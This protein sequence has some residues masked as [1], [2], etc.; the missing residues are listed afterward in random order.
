MSVR[1][2]TGWQTSLA[3]LSLI[4]FM[5]MA[6]VVSRQPAKVAAYP[7]AVPK[8]ARA[9]APS[10]QTEPLSVYIAAPGAPPLDQWLRDQA[11]D[12]RQQ[13]TITARYDRADAGG[14]AR[15]LADAQRLLARAGAL[16]HAARLVVEP[17]NG[18][19]RAALAYDVPGGVDASK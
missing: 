13:L 5:I 14:Q 1:A 2:G 3:D 4:L 7:G 19:P 15:A 18:P 12:P 11:V 10:P 6:S 16:G 17:G 9:E 8:T